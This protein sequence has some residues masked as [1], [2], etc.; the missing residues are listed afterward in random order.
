MDVGC[1]ATHL[2][3]L[4]ALGVVARH[5]GPG[6]ARF[7]KT[8][9][10]LAFAMMNSPAIECAAR[11]AETRAACGRVVNAAVAAIGPD[12][13]PGGETFASFAALVAAVRDGGE[14]GG[15]TD[16]DGGADAGP[17]D[18]GCQLE[19]ALF[20]QQLAVF[21]PQTA[22]PDVL[23]RRLRPYLASHSASLRRVAAATLR[24]VCERDAR[25]VLRASVGTSGGVRRRG[26]VGGG[27]EADLLAL[28]DVARY[29]LETSSAAAGPRARALSTWAPRISVRDGDSEAGAGVSVKPVP[30]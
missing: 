18:A 4:H 22:P 19:A 1:D 20:L 24:H 21:A 15:G 26:G 10:R 6:F 16:D 11:D 12:L 8:A 3:P 13:D 28:L 2:W 9:R 5:V 25:A 14:N 30:G 23:V 17:H 27:I 29:R 7:E